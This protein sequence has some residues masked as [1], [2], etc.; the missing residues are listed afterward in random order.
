LRR[1]GFTLVEM[2]AV[3]AVLGLLAGAVA[4][5]AAGNV[6]RGSRREALDRVIH[7]DRM[8]RL[9][10]R[11]LG[12]GCLLK[13]DL[14]TQRIS[15]FG[16][17]YTVRKHP[18]RVLNVGPTCRIE[19]IWIAGRAQESDANVPQSPQ[20]KWKRVRSG[21]VNVE[22]STA[23]RSVSYAAKVV[24]DGQ[25]GEEGLG[26]EVWVVFS[27]LTGQATTIEDD[28]RKIEKLFATVVAGRPDAH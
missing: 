19:R 22:F 18:S 4:W 20:T 10:A 25:A 15:A 27:G 16:G 9:E 12:K 2:L 5:S 26:D 17:V 13:F 11:R 21:S 28:D 3:V 1:D 24:F 6:R 14:S 7:A 8:A 23:G